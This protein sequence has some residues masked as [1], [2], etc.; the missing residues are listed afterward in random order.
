MIEIAPHELPKPS[1]PKILVI[2]LKNFDVFIE[3][4][5]F[6]VDTYL[7]SYNYEGSKKTINLNDL[8]RK[9]IVKLEKV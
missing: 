7:I 1:K 4:Q 6:T 3:G 9:G 5:I 8:K 2:F